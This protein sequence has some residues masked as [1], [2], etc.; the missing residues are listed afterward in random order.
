LQN[1]T[2]HSITVMWETLE[3]V[4]GTV[5]FGTDGK[6][7][8]KAS[9]QDSVKIHE[10]HLTGLKPGTSYDYRVCYG[11][12][13]LPAAHFETAPV[14]GTRDWRLVVYGDNRSNP[15]T[16]KKN[17][18]Q[19]LALHPGIILNSGDLV[20]RGSVYEQWKTQFFDPLRGLAEH[21]TLFP[22]LG[23][24]EQNADHYYNYMSL[25]NENNEVYYSFDYANAH[26]ISLNSNEED[27]PFELGRPQ[28]Q[29]LIQ[30]L[31]KNQDAE[32]RI[33][34]FHHPLFRCHPTRGVEPQR[35]VWQPIFDR[36]KV[37]LVVCGHDHYYQR[38]YAI[39]NYTG[40]P[41]SGVYHLISGG[42]GAN[43]YP[44]IPAV[45]A[46]FRKRIHHVT[47]I[48]IMDDRMVGRAVD[49][50]GNTF[51]AFILDKQVVNSPEEFVAYEIYQL[52]RDLDKAVEGLPLLDRR[53]GVA[54][55]NTALQLNNPFQVPVRMVVK[56]NSANGWEVT[57]QEEE[58]L[59]EPGLS[60]AIPIVARGK[61]SPADPV[62][63][64]SLMFSKPDGEKA[65]R[66][67]QISVL[68]LKFWHDGSKKVTTVSL[69]HSKL[70]DD[71]TMKLPMPLRTLEGAVLTYQNI[72]DGHPKDGLSLGTVRMSGKVSGVNLNSRDY[73]GQANLHATRLD[74]R[75]SGV[76]QLM[77]IRVR[78]RSRDMH[79]KVCAGRFE[80][81]SMPQVFNRKA[82]EQLDEND[83][84]GEWEDQR[85]G[86]R[87][88]QGTL[89]ITA[90][91]PEAIAGECDLKIQEADGTS[92]VVKA[93]FKVPMQLD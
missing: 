89:I 46:A 19:I 7:V 72:T 6:F 10:V 65:F 21:I 29:W 62:P 2:P 45:H 81:M 43:T 90:Y 37:D 23:N 64:L 24:H 70:I 52:E 53:D 67:D 44:I 51:D 92:T 79:K 33:V 63:S 15:N 41:R 74:I 59:L 12:T 60:F 9:E 78:T 1:V 11:D 58:R 8:Y 84:Y 30:D 26:I 68:P 86:K 34:F 85:D 17:V 77:N 61:V 55:I 4:I 16:H 54:S 93:K 25:P 75:I 42:G 20:A 32:W 76:P 18:Q 48:D 69:A 49:I 47:V 40:E 50:D 83:F 5:E 31:E 80:V 57:P 88:V 35:W 56:W 28:T 73:R 91:T 22:C 14:P 13:I 66:N 87:P 3:P 82:E 38:S 36:Y 27:S 71:Y 39:G